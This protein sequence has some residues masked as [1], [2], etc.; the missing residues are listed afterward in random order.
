MPRKNHGDK[1]IINFKLF[2]RTLFK[3]IGTVDNILRFMY[4]D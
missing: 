1:T 2:A 4:Y 3:C